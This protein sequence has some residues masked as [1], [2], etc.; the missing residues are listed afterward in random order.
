MNWDLAFTVINWLV[1][2]AWLMLVLLPRH[3][4][5]RRLVHS[6][7]Y[8]A[9]LGSI[10]LIGLVAAT[11]F[12]QSAEGVGFFSLSAVALLFDHPNGVIVGWTHYLVFDLF[13]GAW[14]SRDAQRRKISHLAILPSLIGAFLFGPIG[15]LNYLL[16][17]LF[18]DGTASLDEH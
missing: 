10:Y 2:P 13:V 9:I 16:L 8:P 14:I 12:G 11:V 17:R 18:R 7:L 5:T 1:V 6:A 15:L 4:L 3:T